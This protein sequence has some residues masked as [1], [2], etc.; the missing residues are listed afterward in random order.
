MKKASELYPEEQYG[1]YNYQP[2][3]D[4]FGKILIQVDE[5]G[6]QGDIWVLYEDDG[7][8]GYLQFGWGSCS[9]CDA[10]QGCDNLDEVQKLMDS[11]YA[12]IK[13]FE[14]KEEATQWFVSHD[15]EGD[16]CWYTKEFK[17]FLKRVK[18]FFDI[19]I[20]GLKGE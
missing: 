10:L 11:L 2:I 18:T 7:K 4:E 6:Y 14:S 5:D 19:K 17:L 9:G 15:F 13:W 1:Y 20:D 12:S 8:F 16:Y 3:I